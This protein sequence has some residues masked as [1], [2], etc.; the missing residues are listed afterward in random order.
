MSEGY[1]EKG[2]GSTPAYQ[3]DISVKTCLNLS[4]LIP[5]FSMRIL[6]ESDKIAIRLDFSHGVAC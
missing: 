4:I 6:A 5:L 1:V 3:S 2:I